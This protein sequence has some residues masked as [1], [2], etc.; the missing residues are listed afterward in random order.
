MRFVVLATCILVSGAVLKADYQLILSDDFQGP[1]I[2]EPVDPAKWVQNAP[3]SPVT[4]GGD[5][6][7][8]YATFISGVNGIFSATTSNSYKQIKIECDIDLDNNTNI[9][10]TIW[11]DHDHPLVGMYPQQYSGDG[12]DYV[13]VAGKSW[14]RVGN[15]LPH[16]SGFVHYVFEIIVTDLAGGTGTFNVY[17]NGT[18]LALNHSYVASNANLSPAM[19][20][21]YGDGFVDNINMY[22][23]N[24]TIV[25][26]HCGDA[27]TVYKSSDLNHDCYVNFKDLA[28]L[29]TYWAQCTDPATSACDQF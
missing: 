25:P 6:T 3:S 11:A 14:E 20:L 15:A 13:D 27:G 28:I 18:A 19:T 4:I 24:G 12:K 17:R 29:A 9:A 2:G 23:D 1:G 7:N 21:V 10:I 26:K 8:K 5:A 22:T 16:I